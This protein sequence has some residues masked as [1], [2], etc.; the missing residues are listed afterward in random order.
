M[1]LLAGY[2]VGAVTGPDTPERTTATVSSYDTGTGR[3]CLT[4]DAV[5]GQ[6]GADKDGTLCGLWRRGN[7]VNDVPEKGD[8]FRFVSVKSKDSAQQRTNVI[9]GDVVA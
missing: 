5:K 4:G 1:C 2:L 8:K 7:N 3:L 9:Y 6:D